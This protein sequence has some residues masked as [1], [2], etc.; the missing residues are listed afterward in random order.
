MGNRAKDLLFSNQCY[1][2]PTWPFPEIDP[3]NAPATYNPLIDALFGELVEYPLSSQELEDIDKVLM[4]M[5]EEQHLDLFRTTYRGFLQ[6]YAGAMYSILEILV[7]EKN[8]SHLINYQERLEDFETNFRAQ[9]EVEE[10]FSIYKD[11]KFLLESHEGELKEAADNSKKLEKNK[12]KLE[13]VIIEKAAE[14]YSNDFEKLYKKYKSLADRLG[15]HRD[16]INRFILNTPI[17]E[18]FPIPFLRE[19]SSA[20]FILDKVKSESSSKSIHHTNDTLKGRLLA[21]HSRLEDTLPPNL[22]SKRKDEVISY[23][24]ERAPGFAEGYSYYDTTFIPF[25]K[26]IV[27]DLPNISPITMTCEMILTRDYLVT[28]R[29]TEA[30]Q[31]YLNRDNIDTYEE[32]G[33]ALINEKNP[34]FYIFTDHFDINSHFLKNRISGAFLPFHEA[35]RQQIFEENGLDCLGQYYSD[36]CPLTLPHQDNKKCMLK[37]KLRGIWKYTNKE[38]F[39]NSTSWTKPECLK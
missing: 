15:K 29:S 31:D 36:Y 3:E 8:A 22:K 5:H 33:E 9:R 18:S 23:L 13:N 4:S 10:V 30:M 7:E 1:K 27:E 20:G 25:I 39:P 24:D 14:D 17:P 32:L 38:F 12:E 21:L 2:A 26:E 37:D 16:L 35:I 6:L 19:I 34:S 28:K 11:I